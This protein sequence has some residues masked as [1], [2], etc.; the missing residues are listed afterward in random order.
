MFVQVIEGRVADR[1]GLRRQMDNWE[2]DL[3]PGAA[4]FLG[5]TAG[6]TDDGHAIVLARFESAAAAKANSE[7]PEQGRWWAETEK[8]FEGPVTFNDSEDVQ[9]FLAGGSDDAGF[10]QVMK[11]SGVDRDRLGAIDQGFEEHAGS[12]RPD[13]IGVLRIWTAPDAY[14]EVAYFTSEADAREGE[15]KEPPPELAAQMGEFEDMMANIEFLDLR[16]PWLH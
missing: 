5:S 16:D 2:S 15:K 3:R 7:R 1:D 11:G 10:I 9:T 13:L 14:V 12:W 8:N 4:G 6:V